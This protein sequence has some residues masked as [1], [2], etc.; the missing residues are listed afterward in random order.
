MDRA[1]RLIVVSTRAKIKVVRSKTAVDRKLRKQL[2]GDKFAQEV[3]AGVSWIDHHR[4][5]LGRYGLIALAVVVVVGGI[6]FFVRYQSNA[7]VEALAEAMRVDMA[8]VLP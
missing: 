1:G 6:Y 4:S 8:A 2:K 7:R 5:L 3:G